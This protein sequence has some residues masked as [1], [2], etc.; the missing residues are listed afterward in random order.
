MTNDDAGGSVPST[1]NGGGSSQKLTLGFQNVDRF[2]IFGL[3]IILLLAVAAFF[4]FVDRVGLLSYPDRKLHEA[5]ADR[6]YNYFGQ[7]LEYRERRLSL[8]LTFRTFV[9]SFGFTVGLV[10]ATI[11]GI[12]VLGRARANFGTSV[13]TG[14][15][16][17]EFIQRASASITTNSPG[18]VFMLG[19]VAVIMATQYFAIDIGAPEIFPSQAKL[20][21]TPDQAESGIC[22]I[23]PAT[24][25]IG[26]GVTDQYSKDLGMIRGF[27]GRLAQD[28]SNDHETFCK[29]LNDLL[30]YNEEKLR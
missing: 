15:R 11:G 30:G 14:D 20:A 19:G 26:S 21:C 29:I 28:A 1:E 22:W 16:S 10:M 7:A 3:C 2:A 9:T 18:I 24:S 5:F 6:T 8:A 4:H 17:P 13:S 12:F 25:A 27:C 23:D